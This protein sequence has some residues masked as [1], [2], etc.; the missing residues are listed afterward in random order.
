[1][2]TPLE[3]CEQR[4]VKE[5]Y[6]KARQGVIKQFTGVSDPYEPP[7]DPSLIVN[8]SDDLPGKVNQV[9]NFLRGSGWIM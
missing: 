1:V 9:L 2:S 6:K 8:S 4:D 7:V 3:V 5:L